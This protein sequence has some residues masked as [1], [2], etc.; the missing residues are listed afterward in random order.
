MIAGKVDVLEITD[1]TAQP[2]ISYSSFV[3]NS[4][5]TDTTNVLNVPNKRKLINDVAAK[6]GIVRRAAWGQKTPKYLSMDEDF[7]L[8]TPSSFITRIILAQKVPAEMRKNT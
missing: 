6:H 8:T 7:Q 4:L 2:W 5:T 3:K 1:K